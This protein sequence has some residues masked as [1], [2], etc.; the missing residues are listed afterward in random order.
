LVRDKLR[1]IAWRRNNIAHT[2]DRHHDRPD[3]RASI[4]ADQTAETIDWLETIGAAI[5]TAL[6]A[7]D[8]A[9]DIDAVPESA[10]ALGEAPAPIGQRRIATRG[11]S[12]WDE[13]IVRE[14]IEKYCTK[15]VAAT[16]LAI[17]RHAE[18]HPGFRG[19]YFGEGK[20]PSVTAWFNFGNDEAAVWSIYTGL[21]KSVLSINFEWM[22]N[23]GA[24]AARLD[25]LADTLSIL[26]GCQH[27]P[28]DLIASSYAKRPSLGPDTLSDPN[29]AETIIRAVNEFLASL[30][31]GIDL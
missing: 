31:N 6:G 18:G 22:R 29:A 27:L 1:E 28:A 3:K 26:P 11:H 7:A 30:D 19:Y 4:T 13:S 23:R 10:G 20:A 17:Y 9:P 5:L 24:S 16:L 2:A 8:P 15:E 14:T 21:L 12:Q 25:R